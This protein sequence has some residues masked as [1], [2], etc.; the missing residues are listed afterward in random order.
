MERGEWRRDGEQRGDVMERER[1]RGD[2]SDGERGMEERE[3]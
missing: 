2:N 3:E 1:D